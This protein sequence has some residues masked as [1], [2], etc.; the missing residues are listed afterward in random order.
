MI[1][2]TVAGASAEERA[3]EALRTEP[4]EFIRSTHRELP[5]GFRPPS[6]A[7]SPAR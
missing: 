7:D 1:D 6:E 5:F 4:A 2:R 3:L